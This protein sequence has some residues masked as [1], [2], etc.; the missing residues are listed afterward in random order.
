MERIDDRLR[1]LGIALPPTPTPIA[2]Y[3]P[4][5]RVG[6]LAVTA[7][8]VP[9][10]AEG[11]Y[12]GQ[13]G[14]DRT[15]EEGQA[16][17]RACLLNCLASLL[18]VIDSLDWVVQLVRIDGLI[19]SAPGFTGQAAVMNGASDLAVAIFGEAGRHVRTSAGVAGLPNN[20]TASLYITAEVQ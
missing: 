10:T 5:K 18:T 7:G 4:A 9:V 1:A 16:A 6:S 12:T 11:E 2:N 17:A 8:H 19:N 13:L 3:V 15:I 20:Y 14:T